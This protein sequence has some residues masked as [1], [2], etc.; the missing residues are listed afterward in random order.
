VPVVRQNCRAFKEQCDL[1]CEVLDPLFCDLL[2]DCCRKLRN[3]AARLQHLL[4]LR[5]YLYDG[6]LQFRMTFNSQSQCLRPM[7]DPEIVVN[8]WLKLIEKRL[9]HLLEQLLRIALT[10]LHDLN[11]LLD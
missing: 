11:E 8:H 2:V 4:A 10:Q 5:S 6:F 3:G 1:P 9:R 7:K